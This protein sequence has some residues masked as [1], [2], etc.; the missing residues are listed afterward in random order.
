MTESA[1]LLIVEDET[2]VARLLKNFLQAQGHKCSVVERGDLVMDWLKSNRADVIL[3]DVM[4]PGL[5]GMAVCRAIREY[6][7]VPIIMLT[8]RVEEVDQLLGLELGA[9]DYICKPFNMKN[10]AARVSALLRRIQFESDKEEQALEAELPENDNRLLLRGQ[11]VELT[12]TEYRI[13]RPLYKNKGR[14][15]TRAQ[16]LDLAYSD[17]RDVTER[18]IDTHIKS[19]RKK[20]ANVMPELDLIHSIYAMGYKWEG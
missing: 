4:L 18:S 5:D 20:I 19:I 15:Y 17:D 14:I 2:K 7:T 8:A 11:P 13:L 16:L 1:N 9:D 10:V 12:A 6:S 3:L